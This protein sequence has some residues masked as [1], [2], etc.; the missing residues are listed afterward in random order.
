MKSL[1]SA[2]GR[3]LHLTGLGGKTSRTSNEWDK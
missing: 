1:E 3:G 2:V